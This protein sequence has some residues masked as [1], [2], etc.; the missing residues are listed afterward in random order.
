V[1]RPQ[2]PVLGKLELSNWDKRRWKKNVFVKRKIINDTIDI[3]IPISDARAGKLDIIFDEDVEDD[4][5]IKDNFFDVMGA[6]S[7]H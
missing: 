6:S 7:K 3:D 4:S 1:E 2:Q 5:G